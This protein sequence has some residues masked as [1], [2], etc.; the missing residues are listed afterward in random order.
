MKKVLSYRGLRKKKEEDFEQ[1]LCHTRKKVRSWLL[2]FAF[3]FCQTHWC[4][5]PNLALYSEVTLV[6]ALETICIVLGFEPG[7]K[8]QPN[9]RKTTFNL[10]NISIDPEFLFLKYNFSKGQ[11]VCFLFREPGFDPLVAHCL[12]QDQW[13]RLWSTKS[14]LAPEHHQMYLSRV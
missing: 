11:G 14:G 1:F 8:F 7:L 6:G 13:E 12:L 10:C 5:W 4:S 2:L 9:V 3:C